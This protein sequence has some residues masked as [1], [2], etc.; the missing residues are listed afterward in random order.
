MG[1]PI[2]RNT[3][4][5]IDGSAFDTTELNRPFYVA[6]CWAPC[7]AI[8][9]TFVVKSWMGGE[10]SSPTSVEGMIVEVLFRSLSFC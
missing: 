8:I 4:N 9:H 5:R 1:A 3:T 7:Y 2:L 10:V 6:Q